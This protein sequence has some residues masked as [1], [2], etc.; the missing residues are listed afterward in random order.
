M[1]LSGGSRRTA[2]RR[3]G[4]RTA[5][6]EKVETVITYRFASALRVIS[7]TILAR[8]P[9]FRAPVNK[10]S[11]PKKIEIVNRKARFNFHVEESFTAGMLLLGSE[12]K[13]IRNNS[14]N[15]GDGYCQ[16]NEGELFLKNIHISEWNQQGF[17]VH[18]PMRER[19]LL[20]N[21]RELLRIEAKIKSKG[22]TVFP[23]RLFEGDR[24][25]FKMEIGLGQGK[26]TFDKRDDL[27]EKDIKRDLDRGR[28]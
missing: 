16:L 20:L 14:V 26:K 10:K 15:M 9:Y 8:K 11:S 27:K 18:E 13:S 5:D 2:H 22:Y 21:K 1:S 4:A 23:I 7:L 25:I 17:G 24:G 28:F 19:K 3:R 6:F 12:V